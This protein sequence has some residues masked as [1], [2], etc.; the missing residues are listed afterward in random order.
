MKNYRVKLKKII[1]SFK[2][3]PPKI[4][5][6]RLLRFTFFQLLS[7]RYKLRKKQLKKRYLSN[8]LPIISLGKLKM[9]V[10]LN[11]EGLSFDLLINKKREPFLSAILSKI[12]RPGDVVLEIGA[13]IG[14]YMLLESQ[15]IGSQ[16]KIYCLEPVPQNV[17]LLRKN[18]QINNLTNVEVY[19][20]AA[21]GVNKTET[22]FIPSHRNRSSLLPTQDLECKNKL[23]IQVT[24]MDEF[25]QD[26]E[27]PNFIRMDVEGYELEVL[28]GM[29]KLLKSSHPLKIAIEVHPILK[30]DTEKLFRLMKKNGFRISCVTR[31]PEPEILAAPQLCQNIFFWLSRRIDYAPGYIKLTLE[32][33][34]QNRQ[35]ME[36]GLR[37]CLEVVFERP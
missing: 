17:A 5:F 15:I 12:L 23:T 20:L 32:D 1:E 37:K 36:K 14:Y 13:N 26:K 8:P 29:E 19:Q 24:T 25:L 4:F 10:D 2:G 34:L 7:L 27:K 3:D 6:F 11:D 33:F 35:L 9:M 21:G 18:I 22:I 30:S 16:G 31:E 28:K